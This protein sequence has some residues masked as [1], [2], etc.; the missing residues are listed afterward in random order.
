MSKKILV[1]WLGITDL[2]AA[3]LQDSKPTESIGHGPVLGALK[4]LRFD[5]L[6]LLFDQELV[7]AEAYSQWLNT[8]HSIKTVLVKTKLRSPIDFGDIYHGLNKHLQSLTHNS[9]SPD[10]SLHL[11]P[12]TPS[13]AAVSILLGKTKYNTRFVQSTKD[14]GGEFVSIPFDISAEYIPQLVKQA[15]KKLT[16]LSVSDAPASAAFSDIITQN[17]EMLRLIRKAEKIALRDVPALIL[18][19]SGTGKELFAKA[20]HTASLRAGKPF[21]TVNCGAIPKD[22]I[23]SELFGHVKGAFTG[24]ITNKTGY[25]EAAD[26]GTLFLDEFGEL[27]A[28]AQ[29]RLLRVLQSGEISKVGDSKTRHVDIRIIAAANR[30]LSTEIANGRFREDL[31]YRVT[32]GLITLPPLRERSGDISLLADHLMDKINQEASNQPGYINKKISVKARNIVLSH[33][34]PGNIR[35]LYGTLLRA[36]IWAEGEQIDEIDI[37]EAML[38]RPST[39]NSGELPELGTGIDIQE[40][41]DD[42]RRKYVSQALNQA[43]GNKKKAAELLNLPNYQTLSNWMEKLTIE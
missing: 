25:F 30:N 3:K 2:K 11:S 15:D 17:P 14:K 37:R 18:G 32:V 38:I 7:T 13:M 41:L 26:G 31:F 8:K 43:A 24:A 19:E 33:G 12:G 28:D 16:Q 22:L 10:I 27:P 42:I 4:T 39:N 6:H 1:S 35:E 5:E 36:S 9:S 29:V 20:I 34:W 40:I 23:D 21:I